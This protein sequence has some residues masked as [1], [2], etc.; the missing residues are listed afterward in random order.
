[1]TECRC[2]RARTRIHTHTHTHTHTAFPR[3]AIV[4]LYPPMSEPLK[5]FMRWAIGTN[6]KKAK[7]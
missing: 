1:M 5:E 3:K 4:S 6:P 2:K 7:A